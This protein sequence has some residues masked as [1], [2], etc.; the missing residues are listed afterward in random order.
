MTFEEIEM[1]LPNG[2]HDAKI[3]RI[4]LDYLAGTILMTMELLIDTSGDR[5]KYDRAEVKGNKL[6]LCSIEPPDPKYPF[7]PHGKA[8]RVSGDPE[9]RESVIF[10][11]I[12]GEL[13]EGI[14]IYRFFVDSWNSFIHIAASD[15]EI[16]WLKEPHAGNG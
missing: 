16:S 3:V 11:N 1:T 12:L 14:A 10:G 4:T 8:L 15:L 7:K 13:P 5:V 6:Y 9:P 2:F